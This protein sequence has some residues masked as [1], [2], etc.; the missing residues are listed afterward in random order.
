MHFIRNKRT[1]NVPATLQ[2]RRKLVTWSLFFF[3]HFLPFSGCAVAPSNAVSLVY[4]R[5]HTSLWTKIRKKRQNARFL[6]SEAG[7]CRKQKF[8][9]SIFSLMFSFSFLS[10]V[11][12]GWARGC[13]RVSLADFLFDGRNWS[14]SSGSGSFRS[15]F[16]Y[17]V[18]SGVLEMRMRVSLGEKKHSSLGQCCNA[19]FFF[20]FSKVREI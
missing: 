12:V 16:F 9:A 6:F 14:L 19:F 3:P 18:R 10:L 17:M 2:L 13:W 5:E 7:G 4:E 1:S 8:R 15:I 20:F 11:A